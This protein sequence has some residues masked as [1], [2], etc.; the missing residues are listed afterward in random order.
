ME[1]MKQ[2]ALQVI[3]DRVL[4]RPKQLEK[5]SKGGIALEYGSM[6]KV[7][8]MASQ[9]GEV[10]QVGPEAWS[11]YDSQWCKVGD[12]VLF[13]QYSGKFVTDPET[14]EDFIVINDVDIQVI[15]K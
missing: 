13:A 14:E 9:E 7:H 15:I 4:I 11:D 8:K 3:G 6:E 2:M 1:K 10:I 5:M 12:K